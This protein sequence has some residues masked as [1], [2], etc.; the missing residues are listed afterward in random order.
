MK[1]AQNHQKNQIF[2]RFSSFQTLI[3]S[4]NSPDDNLGSSLRFQT[5]QRVSTWADEQ[6]D[7]IEVWELILRDPDLVVES[8]VGGTEIVIRLSDKRGDKPILAHFRSILFVF[9]PKTSISEFLITNR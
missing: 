3:T 7:E 5:F 4:D 1:I 2:H 6:S 8:D 9:P